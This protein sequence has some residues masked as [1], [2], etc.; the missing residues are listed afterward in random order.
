MRKLWAGVV[1]VVVALG[2]LTMP[3]VAKQKVYPVGKVAK[4]SDLKFVVY[5]AQDPYTSPNQFAT[6][7]AGQ[8]YV[9]VDVEVRN[10]KKDQQAF[11]S[12][13]GFQLEDK[14]HHTY[15]E[16]IVVGPPSPPPDGQIPAKGAVRGF[17][18]FAVPDG[19]TGL[20][21]RAKGSFTANGA[22]MALA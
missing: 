19:T 5:G 20:V 3:A 14:A 11:S 16:T 10:P 6:A 7:P 13:I 18:G 15:K 22:L 1:I 8:H 21:L 4:S 9:L 17:V 12:L 2:A